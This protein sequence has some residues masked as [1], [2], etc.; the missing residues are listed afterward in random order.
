MHAA[1]IVI[2]VMII[3]NVV[4]LTDYFLF[5]VLSSFQVAY[6]FMVA[7]VVFASLRMLL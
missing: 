7:V 2:G 5:W 6:A 4:V 3:D 1:C